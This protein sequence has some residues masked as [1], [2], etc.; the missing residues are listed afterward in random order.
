MELFVGL[1]VVVFALIGMYFTDRKGWNATAKRLSRLVRAQLES[2]K[3]LKKLEK[4]VVTKELDSW[5]TEFK[6]L[7]GITPESQLKHRIVKTGFYK[8]TS[9]GLWPE[10]HCK[11]GV[12]GQEPTSSYQSMEGTYADARKSAEKHVDSA[13]KAEELLDKTN[14]NFAW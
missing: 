7:Q 14:G 12:K 1:A 8:T 2:A 3:P 9:Y 5:E 4:K 13:N 11:C 6:Q 10:W